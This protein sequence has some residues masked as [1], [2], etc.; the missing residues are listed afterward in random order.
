[1]NVINTNGIKNI[2]CKW[3]LVQP[4]A[5]NDCKA[6]FMFSIDT[7]TKEVSFVDNSRGNIDMYIWDFGDSKSDSVSF[8]QNPT[9]IYD[10]KGYYTVKLRVENT[11]T[12]CVSKEFRLLNVGEQ[13]VLKA[14]FGYEAYGQNKK[15]A[16]YPVDLVSA[17]SG[18]GATVEWDFGDK[19]I[20][21]GTFTVMDSTSL[22]V[23]HYYQLPGKYQ[24]CLRITDPISGQSDTH[25]DWVNTK[26]GVDVE[27]EI[28]TDL[29][30]NVYPNPFTDLTTINYSIAQ[31][32]NI[33]ISIY[34]QLGRKIETLVKSRKDAGSYQ[35]D[36]KTPTLNPGVYHLKMITNNGTYTRQLVLT[37]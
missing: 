37:K 34:D 15:V 10:Q 31:P 14:S 20:K 19:Q 9:H 17:S 4:N 13:M 5:S 22:R 12:G 8:L 6:D 3:V 26:Y 7:A 21:K 32:D 33:E 36:W 29:N 23:T 2:G 27:E 1:M 24:V 28:F 30:L 25:C 16:G 18:D 11:I 35:I